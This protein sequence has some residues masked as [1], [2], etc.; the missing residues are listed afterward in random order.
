M[1]EEIVIPRWVI[2]CVVVFGLF[3]IGWVGSPRDPSTGRP[4]LLSP[5]LRATEAYRQKVIDWDQQLQSVDRDISSMIGNDPSDLLSQSQE[6]ERI[7][8]QVNRTIQDI[9]IAEHPIAF[10]DLRG[11]LLQCTASYLEVTQ[12]VLTWVSAPTEA[13]REQAAAGLDTARKIRN[14]LEQNSWLKPAP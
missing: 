4:I 9:D 8:V 3:L 7:Q 10:N 13:N 12:Y 2:P 14:D 6:A 11:Q 1:R 5:S